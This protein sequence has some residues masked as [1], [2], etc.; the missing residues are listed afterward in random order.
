MNGKA[1][2]G[3]QDP[4]SDGLPI[5]RRWT[6]FHVN[7]DSQRWV[8]RNENKISRMADVEFRADRTERL[9]METK[10]NRHFNGGH[11]KVG[12]EERAEKPPTQQKQLGV[13]GSPVRGVPGHLRG[14][15][16]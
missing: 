1:H 11:A 7:A 2:I 13:R 10:G 16:T 6:R 9:A 5:R 12:G 4:G 3:R 15:Q 8:D 14:I